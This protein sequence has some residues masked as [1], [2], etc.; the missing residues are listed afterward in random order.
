MHSS[1]KFRQNR[2]NIQ[3]SATIK[4]SPNSARLIHELL[5][6]RPITTERHHIELTPDAANETNEK[7]IP[8]ESHMPTVPPSLTESNSFREIRMNLPIYAYRKRILDAIEYNQVIIISS[9]TGEL[10]CD[11]LS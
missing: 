2:D 4:L 10:N 6:E 1:N 3:R 8:K 7:H 5:T 9:E 11:T